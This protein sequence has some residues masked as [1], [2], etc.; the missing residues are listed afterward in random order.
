MRLLSA[1]DVAI[2]SAITSETL[3]VEERNGRFGLY[4]SIEDSAG[5]IEVHLSAHEAEERID[6]IR[7]RLA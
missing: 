6:R 5:V 1:T 4:Y 7:E 2:A 3:K